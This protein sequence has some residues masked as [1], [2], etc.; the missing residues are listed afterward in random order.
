MQAR[1]AARM[2][3]SDAPREPPH[4]MRSNACALV[5]ERVRSCVPL[6]VHRS[7]NGRALT[8][9]TCPSARR[10]RFAGSFIQKVIKDVLETPERPLGGTVQD[11]AQIGRCTGSK[12]V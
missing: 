4:D 2:H 6:C 12:R 11:P 1:E 7:A 10:S 8:R 5:W 9:L 3:V